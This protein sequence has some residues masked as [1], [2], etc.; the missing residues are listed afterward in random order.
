MD[1]TK[2]VAVTTSFGDDGRDA[3]GWGGMDEDGELMM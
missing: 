1:L 3:G 2:E